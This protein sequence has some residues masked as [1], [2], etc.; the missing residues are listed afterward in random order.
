MPPVV[1][2]SAPTMFSSPMPAFTNMQPTEANSWMTVGPATH[3]NSWIRLFPKALRP[4]SGANAS[5]RQARN[6]ATATNEATARL[7]SFS[8]P[9]NTPHTSRFARPANRN[10]REAM[11]SA[12]DASPCSWLMVWSAFVRSWMAPP[13]FE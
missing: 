2:P 13:P 6:A 4:L 9:Q 11:M 7:R 10:R 1:P 5:I 3:A 12:V 8:R